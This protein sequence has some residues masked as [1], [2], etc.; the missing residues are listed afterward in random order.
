MAGSGGS[1]SNGA[2]TIGTS[3]AQIVAGNASRNGLVVQNNHATN[4]LYV[5][6]SS[7]VTTS[8]GVKVP[9]GGSIEFSEYVGPVFG[10]ASGASTDVRY[11]EVA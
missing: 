6:A 8:N 5:G 11:F 3:A 4:D 1:G 2:A 10:I 7:G 9:A